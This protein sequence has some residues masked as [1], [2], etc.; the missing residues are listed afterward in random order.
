MVGSGFFCVDG[1]FDERRNDVGDGRVEF[2]AWPIEIGGHEVNRV[3]SVLRSVGLHLNKLCE[4]GNAVRGV[5]FFGV[6]LPE[7]VFREG[8]RRELW[9]R[10]NRSDHDGL[11]R[12]L[13]MRLIEYVGAHQ[14]VV[15]VQLGG[16]F[17]VGAN[18]A[19]SRGEVN[20]EIRCRVSEKLANCFAVAQVVVGA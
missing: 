13:K 5:C 1:F 18:A 7:G 19:D 15:E 16:S 4:F 6:A 2:V 9:V 12:V 17:H 3:L 8:D 14:K 10:A 20:D 11:W